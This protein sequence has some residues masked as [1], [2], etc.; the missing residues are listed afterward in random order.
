MEELEKLKDKYGMK[1]TERALELI[2]LQ[3]EDKPEKQQH[4]LSDYNACL[5]W[6]ANEA[7]TQFRKEGLYN[8]IKLNNPDYDEH[9]DRD[10][11]NPT[12]KSSNKPKTFIHENGKEYYTETGKPVPKSLALRDNF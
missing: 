10:K 8:L 3:K 7:I 6:S 4:Y 2:N 11:I 9:K 12:G 5:K 1:V